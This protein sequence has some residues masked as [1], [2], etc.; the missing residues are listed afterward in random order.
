MK[1]IFSLVLSLTVI[2]AV[3]AGVLA[4]VN[5]VT[6]RPIAD[7][8]AKKTV[9]A[10][11]AVLPPEAVDV[12]E[13]KLADG[14]PYYIGK[15][16]AGKIVGYAVKG[17]DPNGYGGDIVL[18]V[19]LRADKQTVVAY[20]TLAAAETP[21][22]GSKMNDPEFSSQFAGKHISK[23]RIKKRGGEIEAITAAPITS[24]AVCHAVKQAAA[25]LK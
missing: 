14:E 23:I 7:M 9:A 3:C 20:R 13:A 8:L 22:L 1:K 6:A 4:Y 10:A 19:G 11:K 18:M 15:D 5:T 12:T 2:S 21:G 17:S 25:K 24:R 16:A